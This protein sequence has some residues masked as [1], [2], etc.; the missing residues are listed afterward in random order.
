VKVAARALG[1]GVDRARRLL[2]EM[3]LREPVSA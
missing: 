3:K 1:T 2:D